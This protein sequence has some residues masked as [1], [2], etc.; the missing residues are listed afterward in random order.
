MA[1]FCII[2]SPV[3]PL[4]IWIVTVSRLCSPYET[5]LLPS[6]SSQMMGSTLS[7]CS[8]PPF[9]WTC[10]TPSSGRP[11]RRE[12]GSL[13]VWAV[14]LLLP[15][16]WHEAAAVVWRQWLVW[17]MESTETAGLSFSHGLLTVVGHPP[18]TCTQDSDQDFFCLFALNPNRY[19]L[20]FISLLNF[21]I[22]LL[23]CRD[24]FVAS[25]LIT[26]TYY[27]F[28]MCWV[29]SKIRTLPLGSLV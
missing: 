1:R 13:V 29:L 26:N 22:C 5:V 21:V 28:T 27:L 7:H 2:R 16:F 15:P 10:L 25:V 3:N 18:T 20:N 11:Q 12:H 9:L 4:G 24:L 6:T 17:S 8:E 23:D 14:G 19:L